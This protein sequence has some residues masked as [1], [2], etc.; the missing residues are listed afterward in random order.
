MTE[1][2]NA[3]FT[4]HKHYLMLKAYLIFCLGRTGECVMEDFLQNKDSCVMESIDGAETIGHLKT[5]A[6]PDKSDKRKLFEA[7]ENVI[8]NFLVERESYYSRLEI[9]HDA[10]LVRLQK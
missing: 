9:E 4:L 7:L 6:K 3:H 5:L 1:D 2:S 10:S 8:Q